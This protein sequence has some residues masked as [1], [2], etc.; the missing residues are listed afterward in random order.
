M[1]RI[2]F[3][4]MAFIILLV[5]V[6]GCAANVKDGMAFLEEGKYSHALEMF[7]KDIEKGR[8]LE[9][10][11]RGKGI[12]CFELEEYGVAAESFRLALENEAEET[13]TICCLLGA[14]YMEMEE[15]ERALD[16]YENALLKEDITEELRQEAEFNLIAAYE[17]MGNWEAAKKQME[18]YVESYPDDTRIEKEAEFLET[19]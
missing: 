15:Y 14:C 8:N 16:A 2:G 5:T 13:A 6:T 18:K 1:K 17:Y 19:R 7:E 4:F 9:E 11:Y 10:A 12:A 3:I